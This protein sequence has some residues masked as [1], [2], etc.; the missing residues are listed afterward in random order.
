MYTK[1]DAHKRIREA[2]TESLDPT[3]ITMEY[4]IG[5][6]SWLSYWLNEVNKE[7]TFMHQKAAKAADKEIR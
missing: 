7:I 4:L 6:R 5:L 3:K 2:W 1:D